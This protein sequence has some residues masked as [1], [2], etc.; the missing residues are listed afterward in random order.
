MKIEKG[1]YIRAAEFSNEEI[2]VFIGL[3]GIDVNDSDNDSEAFEGWESYGLD[4]DGDLANWNNPEYFGNCCTH[5]KDITQEFRYYIDTLSVEKKDDDEWTHTYSDCGVRKDCILIH[6]KPDINGQ[7]LVLN[8]YGE[9]VLTGTVKL[10]PIKQTIKPS[11]AWSLVSGQVLSIH[12]FN[13]K[14]DVVGK[15]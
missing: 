6:Y 15:D 2:D 9:Y 5:H 11:A 13:E 4:T 7:V 12:E 3:T 8:R 1:N 14:Y 10:K